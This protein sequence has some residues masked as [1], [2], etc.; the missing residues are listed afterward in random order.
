[1]ILLIVVLLL[2]IP[3]IGFSLWEAIKYDIKNEMR[4]GKK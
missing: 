3:L 1:M 2:T 4:R